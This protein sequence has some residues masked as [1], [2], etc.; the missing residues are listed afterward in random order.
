MGIGPYEAFLALDWLGQLKRVHTLGRRNAAGVDS[1][2]VIHTE[3]ESGYAQLHTGLD[4]LSHGD[5]IL[6]GP[7]GY[8]LIDANWW[9]PK[10]ATIH[11]RDGRIVELNEPFTAGGFNYETAHFCDLIRAG[12]KESPEIS[13]EL[14][15]GMARLLEAA[16]AALGVVFP[17]E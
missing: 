14:S 4:L 7:L 15:L 3:H 9:N 11:Y 6:C 13:H 2:A 16:R 8:A 1:F 17:G 10:R 5:A 12:V